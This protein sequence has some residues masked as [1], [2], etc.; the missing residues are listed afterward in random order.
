VNAGRPQVPCHRLSKRALRHLG[1]RKFRGA[2]HAAARR[3]G[4][5][6]HDVAAGPA[7]HRRD[8]L[9]GAV[10]QTQCIGSPCLLEVVG[11]NLIDRAP[12]ALASV[13]D[14]GVD[15][16]HLGSDL[17][18]GLAD[19]AFD[20]DVAREC[21]CV[22]QRRGELLCPL[23]ATCQQCQ[24]MARRC[25]LAGEC[26]TIARPYADDH[27]HGPTRWACHGR[28]LA[29][30]VHRQEA[31]LAGGALVSRQDR[32]FVRDA[33]VSERKLDLPAEG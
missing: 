30:W 6:D 12:H 7:L 1:R 20:G 18:E 27:T 15:G 21:P 17:S 32:R 24:R 16:P 23:F 14:Q 31:G 28:Q 19:G 8:H 10:E 5:D 11:R 22:G 29:V 13:V 33:K 3:G 4:A 9:V 2:R 25:E 26:L